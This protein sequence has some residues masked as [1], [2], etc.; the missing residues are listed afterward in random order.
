MYCQTGVKCEACSLVPRGKLSFVD[1][2]L[3]TG[4]VTC[5]HLSSPTSMMWW[6]IVISFL[7]YVQMNYLS[8]F[9]F[10]FLDILWPLVDKHRHERGFKLS[11]GEAQVR[12]T[13]Q[14]NDSVL[15]E[16][17]NVSIHSWSSLFYRLHKKCITTSLPSLFLSTGRH[18][19]ES[20]VCCPPC[21]TFSPPEPASH[22]SPEAFLFRNRWVQELKY[23]MCWRITPQSKN[24]FHLWYLMAKVSRSVQVMLH[25]H[26]IHTIM[27]CY[28]RWNALIHLKSREIMLTF[29]TMILVL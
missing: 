7:L 29:Q 13:G 5:E 24:V 9:F 4:P 21:K 8:V 22:W 2:S 3:A 26:Q 19:T 20:P 1:V 23:F 15:L 16:V 28:H 25:Y 12:G 17:K 18:G 6:W 11:W 27:M 10:L 14:V